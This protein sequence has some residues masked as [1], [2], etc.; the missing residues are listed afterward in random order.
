MIWEWNEEVNAW[1]VAAKR[2]HSEESE[3]TRATAEEEEL[4]QD[5]IKKD[6]LQPK[7]SMETPHGT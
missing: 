2:G 7:T 6:Y 3:T 4:Q 5:R 1:Q